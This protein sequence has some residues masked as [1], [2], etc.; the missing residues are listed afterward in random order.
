VSTCLPY[1]SGS[2]G[3]VGTGASGASPALLAAEA[4]GPPRFFLDEDFRKV[5]LN[6][7]VKAGEPGAAGGGATCTAVGN[8][9]YRDPVG[10]ETQKRKVRLFKLT[11]P[12]SSLPPL[13]VGQELEANAA[14]P[15]A[16]PK[17]VHTKPRNHKHN[18]S[19]THGGN[20]YHV[21]LYV[22]DRTP[23]SP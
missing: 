5:G 20:D 9:E 3:I 23:D 19:V 6:S 17:V 10:T 21:Q 16:N 18:H 7:Y 12:G 14:I 15:A 4:G 22:P 8:F 11:N 2:P 13:Y 1:D